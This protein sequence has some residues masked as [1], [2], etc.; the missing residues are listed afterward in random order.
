MQK[1]IEVGVLGATGMVGQ[2]FI[3]QL[4]GHPWFS[5]KWLAASE[6][7]FG[8]R[9]SDA[10]SWRL[11]TP[12]PDGIADVNVE[13]CTPGKGPR[14]VFSALDAERR[15]RDRAGVRRR[16]P[17][18]GQ[19]LA[20]PPDG[21]DGATARPG[22]EPRAPRPAARAGEAAR[23]QGG[24][25]HQPQLLD[26]RPDD[27]ARAAAR[28]RPAILP[29]LDAC[30]PCRARA[31]PASRRS[32]SSATWSPSSAAR[33]RRS[34]SR[35]RKILGTFQDGAVE[36]HP[37]KV[38]APRTACRSSTATPRP[39]RWPSSRSRRRRKLRAALGL[40]RGR[41][42]ASLF[43]PRRTADPVHGRSRTGRS[44]A[45]TPAAGAA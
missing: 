4:A 37:M 22:G 24:D 40:Q 41:R 2:Q 21:P 9:Y 11:E 18:R 29:G 27:G 26:R 42:S 17:L 10:A 33:R 28:L 23:R 32:T 8:K 5:L 38:S 31:T 44:R 13:P 20:Q 36:H 19:Q 3:N 39:Y 16:R 43:P 1:R 15:G 14:L 7:S 12:I 34:K 45:S 25:R 30:R 6:R 35:R